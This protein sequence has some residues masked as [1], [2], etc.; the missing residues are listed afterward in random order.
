VQWICKV[1]SPTPF[2][3]TF[4]HT[5][6]LTPTNEFDCADALHLQDPLNSTIYCHI[7]AYTCLEVYKCTQFCRCLAFERH[8]KTPPTHPIYCNIHA[9]T[10]LKVYDSDTTAFYSADAL[11]VK[12]IENPSHQPHLLP[13]AYTCL[14]VYKCIQFCRCLPIERHLKPPPT[15]PIYCFSAATFMHTR[16]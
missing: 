10:C 6:A 8:L 16:A 7:H 12:G 9:Y 5:H 1:L 11:H 2:T 15:N 13:H 14:E 3:A 4:M